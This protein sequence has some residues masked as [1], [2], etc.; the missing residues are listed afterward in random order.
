MIT[1][2]E[3]LTFTNSFMFCNI[4]Q[5]DPELC[6]EIVETLLDVK[7]IQSEWALNRKN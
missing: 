2:Y 4:L 3:K 5:K 7:R 6:K 1:E